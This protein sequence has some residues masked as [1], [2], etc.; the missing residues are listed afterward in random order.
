MA[1]APERRKRNEE[2]YAIVGKSDP[3]Q[4][5][6]MRADMEKA[7]LAETD[8]LRK[9]DAYERAGMSKHLA[10]L[11][12]QGDKYRAQIAAMTPQERTSPAFIVGDDL[13]PAGTPDANAIVRKN[14]AF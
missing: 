8:K 13:V 14:A 9:G 10:S 12:A 1:E 5:A 11:T 4:A 6:K 7:E 2:L 3:A